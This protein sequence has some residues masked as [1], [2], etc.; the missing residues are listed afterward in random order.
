L[1]ELDFVSTESSQVGDIEDTVI[2][3]GVFSMDTS[4]LDVIFVSNGLMH[5]WVF[6]EFWEV[7]VNGSSKTGSEVGW[8]GRDVTE[9][10]VVGELSFSFNKAG[11]LRESRENSSNIGSLLHGDDSKL[12]FFVNPDEESLG[13]VMEDSSTLWPVSLESA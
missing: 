3:F 4:D 11:S 12:I 13:I 1:D 5:F 9:M 10:G 6:H 7:D 2:S 8:A